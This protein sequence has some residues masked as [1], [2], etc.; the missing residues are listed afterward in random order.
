[1]PRV[2]A[3]LQATL[4]LFVVIGELASDWP[5]SKFEITDQRLDDGLRWDFEYGPCEL[6]EQTRKSEESFG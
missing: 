1:M 3:A 2:R 4:T 6:A 5:A